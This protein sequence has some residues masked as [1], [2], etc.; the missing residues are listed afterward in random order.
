MKDLNVETIDWPTL[1]L[2]EDL[3]FTGHP[4]EQEII[5]KIRDIEGKDSKQMSLESKELL[6]S[7]FLECFCSTPDPDAQSVPLL[8]YTY[9]Q[10]RYGYK[11][12][13]WHQIYFVMQGRR[14]YSPGVCLFDRLLNL[15]FSI[16]RIVSPK[17]SDCYPVSLD[18]FSIELRGSRSRLLAA[19]GFFP[20]T[21]KST[22]S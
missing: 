2:Y 19:I 11:K 5:E 15:G 22:E 20:P 9:N 1:H 8:F 7:H 4:E 10:D 17:G 13:I 21:H 16:G 18:R 14:E 6:V 3:D 12:T